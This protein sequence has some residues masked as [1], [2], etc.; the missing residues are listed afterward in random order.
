M[1]RQASCPQ[2]ATQGLQTIG[3]WPGPVTVTAAAAEATTSGRRHTEQGAHPGTTIWKQRRVS[4]SVVHLW[5]TAEDRTRHA[6]QH[7]SQISLDRVW[8]GWAQQSADLRFIR[9]YTLKRN[10][11]GVFD[12]A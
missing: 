4:L 3:D 1:G 5:P 8:I 10:V 6:A 11:F 2:A 9:F 7:V 12:L